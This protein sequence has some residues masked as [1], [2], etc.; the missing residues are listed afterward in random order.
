[1]TSRLCGDDAEKWKEAKAAVI[2]CLQK[3]I[4]LWDG[5][6]RQL[7]ENRASIQSDAEIPVLA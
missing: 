1:M 6:Y 4:R 7:S 2:Q 5:V 3:R